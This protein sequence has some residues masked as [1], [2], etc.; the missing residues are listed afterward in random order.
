MPYASGILDGLDC[1]V[2][3]DEITIESTLNDTALLD[4]YERQPEPA[5]HIAE[6][7]ANGLENSTPSTNEL[8]NQQVIDL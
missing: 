4:D 5:V 3:E 2:E 1:V 7:L 6:L 8:G